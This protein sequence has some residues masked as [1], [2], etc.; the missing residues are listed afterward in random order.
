MPRDSWVLVDTET[1]GLTQPIHA[2]EIAAQRYDGFEPVG[3]PFRA[4]LD[5]G[6]RISSAAYGVH[7]YDAEFL[8]KSGMAPKQAYS[9]FWDYVGG[10]RIAAHWAKFDWHRVL[11]PESHR[12]G[13]KP[14]GDFGFC[15][16]ALARR[17]MPELFTWRL[18]YLRQSCVL[19]SGRPH[20]AYGD[21]I[22]AG[23]LVTRI[24]RMRM[25][26]LGF[27]TVSQ[28]A[29]FSSLPVKICGY[30]VSL[31]RASSPEEA[32]ENAMSLVEEQ[33]QQ[34]RRTDELL[35]RLAQCEERNLRKFARELGLLEDHTPVSFQGRRFMFTGTLAELKRR[36][37]Q[38]AV[39][40]MEGIALPKVASM[41]AADYLV[42]GDA[43]PGG[44]KLRCAIE[45]RINGAPNPVLLSEQ[46]FLAALSER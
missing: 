39:E 8:K 43:A 24:V 3:Q 19:Q 12:L 34:L 29:Y 25:S 6:I 44:G 28:L 32:L 1:D 46:D 35:S 2:V 40:E 16:W 7:G 15:T 27:S 21:V 26:R 38:A 41:T 11:I 17:S 5:H 30:I 36:F 23:D 20:T 33:E 22:A 14:N 42:L 4:F 9:A 10:D 37:A 31:E 45:Q 13:V 18:D